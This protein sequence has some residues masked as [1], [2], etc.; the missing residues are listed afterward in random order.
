MRI[1]KILPGEHE[2]LAALSDYDLSEGEQDSGL[3]EVAQLAARLFHV[4]IALVT[5]VGSARQ[6]F[7]GRTGTEYCGTD[8]DVSFCSHA[9]GSDEILVVPDSALDPRFFDNPLVTGDP[10]VRFY[11]GAPLRTHAGQVLGTLCIIDHEPRNGLSARDRRSLRHL[12][13]LALD[14]LEHRRLS[15][16]G[17]VG[18]QRFQNIAATS[19]DAIVCADRDGRITF[20]N[21][22]AERL[23]GY[24]VPEALGSDLD[25][26][27]PQRMRGGHR[28]GLRGVA[29]GGETRLVGKTIE[30]DALH[31]NGREIPVELSLSMWHEGGRVS[32]GAIIRDISE[33]RVNEDKLFQLAHHDALTGLPNRTVLFGRIGELVGRGEP[34]HLLYVDLDGFKPVNDTVG[35]QVG[36]AVLKE[37]AERLVECARSCDTVARVGGDEFVLLVP[38]DG[39]QGRVA[40]DPERM[41]DCVM[42]ALC[43]PFRVAGHVVHLG[44]S[45][46]IAST[47]DHGTTADE[48]ISAADLAMYQAKR[49]GRRCRRVF[50]E[51][52]RR[53]AL[54]RRGREEELRR[55][56]DR[57]EFTLFYQ[58]QVSLADGR[59]IGAE[60]LIRWQHPDRGLLDPDAFL[61]AVEEALLAVEV[62]SWVLE[63]ACAQAVAWR[64][65]VPGFRMAVNLF[66]AQFGTGTLAAQVRSVLER[67][68]LEPAGLELEVTENV[69]LRHDTT[70]LEAL[71]ALHDEGVAVAFDDFG[72]GFASLSM[73]KTYPLSRLKIDRS[74]VRDISVNRTD[75]LIVGT[76]AAL[77][78][79]LG[80]DVIAEGVE[81]EG[82]RDLLHVSG[83]SSGQGFL[84]GRP[85]PAAAFERWMTEREPVAPLQSAR[86]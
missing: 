60:A 36:D 35:H 42:A 7:A 54:A 6:V 64:R 9:L 67:T 38:A 43:A 57:G 86:Q 31:K 79:G 72:T 83:C 14:K 19:P 23:F 80:L 13:A 10:H 15:V 47:P 46:G 68:G 81:D 48:L 44:A 84:F 1:A 41:A 32:F 75:A 76:V 33:R 77:G 73:L 50:S 22:T 11:A 51:R 34:A 78:N 62:G 82:Q 18:Q 5:L 26:I 21:A 52:L 25:I 63:T 37:V 74:F 27:V 59:V 53:E 39:N 65:R 28:N 30:L 17:R 85:M 29:D 69:I 56:T 8:R 40:A 45:I 2:R 4:P 12:A 71:R 66:E 49:E 58:P 16:A 20:W 61:P 55:A 24:G 3:Q 70:M